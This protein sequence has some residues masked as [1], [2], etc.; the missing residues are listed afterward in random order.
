MKKRIVAILAA[1]LAA[2][3]AVGA[4]NEEDGVAAFLQRFLA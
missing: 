3:D 4:S 2:A 1:L